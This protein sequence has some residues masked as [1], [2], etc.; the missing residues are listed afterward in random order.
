MSAL[1]KTDWQMP[2]TSLGS[3]T[4]GHVLGVRGSCAPSNTDSRGAAK[5]RGPCHPVDDLDPPVRDT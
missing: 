5:D 2:R 1:P 4:S 3:A